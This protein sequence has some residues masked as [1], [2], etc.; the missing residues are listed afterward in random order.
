MTEY[1]K[2]GPEDLLV[3][4]T[5]HNRGPEAAPLE[6]PPHLRLPNVWSWNAER[7]SRRPS[8]ERDTSRLAVRHAWAGPHEL[9]WEGEPEVLLTENETN[10]PQLFG[11]HAPGPSKDAFREHVVEG[12]DAHATSRPSGTK[13]SL[14]WRFDAVP[15]GGSATVRLRLGRQHGA[16]ASLDGFDALV[17]RRREEA[18]AFH[19]AHATDLPDDPQLR[20]IHRQA[21][22]GMIWPKQTHRYDVRRWLDGDAAPPALPPGRTRNAEWRHLDNADVVSMPDE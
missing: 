11:A 4:I 12:R 2:A 5:A 18:D 19:A 9:I 16:P 17:S 7:L 22:V 21:L 10:V 1:A 20:V 14:R 13:S 3:P 8:I 6:L 15:A